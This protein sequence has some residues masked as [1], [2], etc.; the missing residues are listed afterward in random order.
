MSAIMKITVEETDVKFSFKKY[1]KLILSVAP[2]WD[3]LGIKEIRFVEKFYYPKSDHSSPAHYLRGAN[4]KNAIIELNLPNVFEH[5][6][7]QYYFEK[8]PE[9]AALKLSQV[10]FHEIGHHAHF[11]KRHGIKKKRHENFA[12]K[13]GAAGYLNYLTLR[14]NKIIASYKWAERNIFEWSKKER[15]MF[16]ENR[17]EIT[18]WLKKNKNG[19]PF[20]KN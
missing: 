19:M 8:H 4:G 16:K 11:H 15:N 12:N 3:I 9:I 18:D 13:Y 6:V 14:K 5:I 7:S 1:C 20:P 10:I 17:Q 2:K